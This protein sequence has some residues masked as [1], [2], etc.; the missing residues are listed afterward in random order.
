LRMTLQFTPLL[1]YSSYLETGLLLT[2]GLSVGAILI[3]TALAIVMVGVRNIGGKWVGWVVDA[4]VELMR[5]TPFLVQ[6][7][8]IFF[9]LPLLG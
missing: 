1:A 4:Y 9:G 8:M 2:I 7:F 5:N 3:G 6:L